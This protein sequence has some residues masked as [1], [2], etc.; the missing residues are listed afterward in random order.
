M[1]SKTEGVGT[2]GEPWTGSS[3]AGSQALSLFAAPLN[4]LILRA[5]SKGPMRLS[6][7]RQR[8]GGPAQTTLRAYLCNLIEVG[9][10]A[11]VKHNEM[12]YAVTHELSSQGRDLLFVLDI[13]EAWLARAPQGGLKLGTGAAKAAVKAFTDGWDATIVQAMVARPHSL[14][15]LDTLISELS[16]P[17]LERRLSALRFAGLVEAAPASGSGTPYA[18]SEWARRGIAPLIAAARWEQVN[19][20]E[21]SEP[22]TWVETEAGFLMA[23]ALVEL[24]DGVSGECVLALDTKGAERRIAGV[25]VIVE[26]GRLVSCET[27]LVAEPPTFALGNAVAWIDAVIERR[28]GELHVNGDRPLLSA[29]VGGIHVALFAQ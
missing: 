13:L 4:P 15:E 18:I 22:V 7:L 10:V 24:A 5:L 14:T 9:V 16:Y 3:R 23:L 12:P 26:H 2:L 19:A 6:E 21:R 11:K 27:D 25:H 28:L 1:P 8:V 29:L 17:A 20:P